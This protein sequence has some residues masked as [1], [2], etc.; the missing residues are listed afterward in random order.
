M[1]RRREFITLLG[2]AAAWPLA[3]KA[4]QAGRM[5]RIG[6]LL[7]SAADDP[8]SMSRVTAFLQGLQELGWTD[9]R[10]VRIDF[11]WGAGD[12]EQYGKIASDLI[13][14]APDVVLTLGT[15]SVK[16]LQ[17]ATRTVP[18]VFAQTTDPV[19]GGLVESLARPGGNVTGFAAPEFQTSGKYVE[20]LKEAA[21]QLTHIAVTRDPGNA[22]GTAQFAAIQ[23][24]A[25]SLGMD[26]RPVDVRETSEIERV[27]AA[28]ARQPNTGLIVTASAPAQIHRDL[29]IALAAQ[30]RLPAI[31]PY[32]FFAA[33]GGLISYG[34]DQHDDFRRAAG[35][36]DRILKGE[37]PAD[38][39]VQAPTKFELVINLKTAKTL[40][41]TLPPGL[42]ARADDVIE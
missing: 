26:T 41:L 30:H 20:V 24:V 21:P 5:R 18:I 7:P 39:P 17:R 13:A 1:I 12:A 28:A 6:V 2:G 29:L 8:E 23:T 3:A 42:L 40:G 22:A 25:S 34:V 16:A 14:L 35:Y 19:G 31:Y 36:V 15:L 33:D 27:V 11:R 9:G 38:L 32:R 4:Q 37:K 10:N